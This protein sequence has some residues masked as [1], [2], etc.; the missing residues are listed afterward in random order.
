MAACAHGIALCENHRMSR[1]ARRARFYDAQR[2]ARR[3]RRID[4]W[5]E[6]AT[7]ILRN[8]MP[9]NQRWFSLRLG[10]NFKRNLN[11]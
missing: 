11:S 5:L 6:A 8:A 2:D 3:M 4:D 10:P 1:L 9:P 7:R